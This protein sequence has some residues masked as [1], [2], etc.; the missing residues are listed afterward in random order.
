MLHVVMNPAEINN[1]HKKVEVNFLSVGGSLSNNKLTFEDV[2]NGDDILDMALERRDGPLNLRSEVQVL[3]PSFGFNAKKWAFGFTSQVFVKADIL[4]LNT[5][6]GRALSSDNSINRSYDVDLRSPVNQRVNGAGWLELGLTAGREVV[7]TQKHHL[8]AGTTLKF[9][10]PAVYVNLGM[11]NLRGTLTENDGEYSLSNATGEININ[12]PQGYAN[13]DFFDLT[14]RDFNL[15]NISGMA[16]DI[17]LAHQLKNKAGASILS[18]GIS[19]RNLGSF[20]IASGQT[21]NTYSMNIPAGE[22]F[23]LDLLDG[24]LDEIEEQ[25]LAS[26]YFSRSRGEGDFKANIPTIISVY[27]DFRVGS[28]LYL[29]LYGQR[30]VSNNY[31]NDQISTQNVISI[32]PRIVLGKL[33]IYSPWARYEVSGITGGLGLRMGGFFVGSQSLISGLLLNEGM[34][35]DVHAG[36]SWGFGRK[37]PKKKKRI[38]E[39]QTLEDFPQP[40][41]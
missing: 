9:L 27:T 28:S 33:E 16:L 35:A 22:S 36:L 12:Y 13:D 38:V 32:T 25:L 30:R 3:G 17:G 10:I 40:V 15:S 5:D 11:N 34:M 41:D 31:N 7:H 39:E 37:T 23:R 18:S 4:D 2:L 20:N 14:P 21:N 6:L 29:G 19:V 8:S 1:L 26:G 24:E